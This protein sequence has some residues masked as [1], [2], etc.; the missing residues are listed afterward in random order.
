M[1]ITGE[2]VIWPTGQY[3]QTV[4]GKDSFSLKIDY[5]MT[6]EQI[7]TLMKYMR[8][9]INL[10]SINT[11]LDTSSYYWYCHSD[12]CWCFFFLSFFIYFYFIFFCSPP[13]Q[14]RLSGM[15]HRELRRHG[16]PAHRRPSSWSSRSQWLILILLI[17]FFFSF[18]FFIYFYFICMFF[19]FTFSSLEKNPKQNSPIFT[20]DI[21]WSIQGA[22][23][24]VSFN[25]QASVKAEWKGPQGAQETWGSITQKAKLPVQEIHFTS[26]NNQEVSFSVGPLIL[27]KPSK[28]RQ[29]GR[30]YAGDF[31][32]Q[33]D[34]FHS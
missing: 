18:S 19:F 32:Y 16:A 33:G 10:F 9:W 7:N 1:C 4:Q 2:L 31:I 20:P 30:K 5:G 24:E 17:F 11:N 29:H 8:V 23:Q 26:I 28:F 3:P 34:I 12:Y 13:P 21:V 14:W 6:H 22:R 27:T 25:A 15:V